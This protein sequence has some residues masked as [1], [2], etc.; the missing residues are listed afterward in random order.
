[1][2]RGRG[3]DDFPTGVS[4]FGDGLLSESTCSFL[5]TAAQRLALVDSASAL[6][7][8]LAPSSRVNHLMRSA[9]PEAVSRALA[10]VTSLIAAEGGEAV[11]DEECLCGWPVRSINEWGVHQDRIL[12]LTT[13]ALWRV[14]WAQ[15]WNKVESHSRTS[16]KLVVGMRRRGAH[17]QSTG[18]VLQLAERDGRANPL[19]DL[20]RA[21]SRRRSKGWRPSSR[22]SL[23][24]AGTVTGSGSLSRGSEGGASGSST[25]ATRTTYERAYL[26]VSPCGPADR[27]QEVEL[28][29]SFSSAMVDVMLAAM[30]ACV[31]LH[32]GGVRPLVQ[33]PSIAL[34]P[35]EVA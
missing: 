31:R 16:L 35:V 23:G 10:H 6:R 11:A 12:V 1:M 24:S 33:G 20:W 30:E 8:A 18:M 2:A 14:N 13:H 4:S 22:G 17:A 26:A 5:A 7:S 32:Q 3:G 25:P 34:H 9:R 15:E 29:Q 28:R 19:S 21:S 27:A